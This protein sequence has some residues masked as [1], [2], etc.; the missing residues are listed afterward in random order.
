MR[1]SLGRKSRGFD[2]DKPLSPPPGGPVGVVDPWEAA[3]NKEMGIN[4]KR[5]TVAIAPRSNR[6][7]R[8][9]DKE[10]EHLSTLASLK[11]TVENPRGGVFED[12]GGESLGVFGSSPPPSP[13]A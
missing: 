1:M 8:T 2:E 11:G 5:L 7:S 13:H 10:D 6:V 4:I 12:F 9:L 3:A